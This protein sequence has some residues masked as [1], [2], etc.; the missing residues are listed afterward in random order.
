[1][2][3]PK[4][5]QLTA[6]L[7]ILGFVAVLVL[8]LAATHFHA[9]HQR[10]DME[11]RDLNDFPAWEWNRAALD[12]FPAKF[13]A[14]F[15]DHFGFRDVFTRWHS[16]I[17]V[18]VLG[19]SPVDKVILGKQEWLYLS[20]SVLG[21]KISKDADVARW[22][23]ELQTKQAWLAARGIRYLLVV[24]P[25]KEE[26]YPEYLPNSISSKHTHRYL[27]GILKGLSAD[28]RVNILD[29][30]E[31]LCQGRNLGLVFDRTDT[32]W[33]HLGMFLATNEILLR[34]QRW[35][36]ELQPA[37]L[38]Q[39]PQTPVWGPGGDLARMVGLQSELGEE[40]LTVSP[41]PAPFQEGVMRS[42]QVWP[43]DS[44]QDPPLIYESQ[45]A[46]QKLTVLITG[47]SF[48]RGLL[49]FLP[50][51]FRRVVRL[52]PDVPYNA[53]FQ[54]LLPGLVEAEKPDVYLDVLCSRSLRYPPKVLFLA[55]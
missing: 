16:L 13:E 3:H 54:D 34:L 11:N 40:R 55:R 48:G 45:G 36:P 41:A 4:S 52:R 6:I 22:G 35:Y 29:L 27:D 50:E 32:H 12:A 30:R 25:N 46:A 14:A 19:M 53:W 8:P 38:D 42:K 37:P 9:V 51:H 5:L 18:Y 15:N 20:R 7:Q 26:V 2:S 49:E 21:N 24:P 28:F 23:R 31:P 10:S 33:S 43:E 39:R 1:M 47:D 44:L 17:K